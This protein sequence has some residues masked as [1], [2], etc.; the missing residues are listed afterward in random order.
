MFDLGL[1]IHFRLFLKENIIFIR[2]QIVSKPKIIFE[3][4]FSIILYIIGTF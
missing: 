2:N 4:T 3:M 1:W